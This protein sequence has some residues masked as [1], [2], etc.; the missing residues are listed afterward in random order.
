MRLVPAMA[1]AI[2]TK[3]KIPT[4]VAV[5]LLELMTSS[6]LPEDDAYGTGGM[7]PDRRSPPGVFRRKVSSMRHSRD[8]GRPPRRVLPLTV[9]AYAGDHNR[10]WRNGEQ[11]ASTP[12]TR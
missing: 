7:T 3:N 5:L 10:R 2:C 8:S 12:W 4:A 1:V 11:G 6:P 9:L